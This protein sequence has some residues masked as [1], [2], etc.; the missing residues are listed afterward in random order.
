MHSQAPAGLLFVRSAGYQQ[1]CP[2]ISVDPQRHFDISR[3][4]WHRG[5]AHGV[6]VQ[7]HNAGHGEAGDQGS[8]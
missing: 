1:G 6:H 8:T 5:G 2:N 3:S 7:G 4:P